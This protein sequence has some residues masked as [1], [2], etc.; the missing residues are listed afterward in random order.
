MK[1]LLA[2]LFPFIAAAQT[3]DDLIGTWKL[4]TAWSIRPGGERTPMYGERP[5]GFLTYTREGRMIAILGNGERKRL[6][7][8]RATSPEAERAEAFSTMLSYGG[9]FSIED[10]KVIH[11]VDI[12]TYPNFVGTDQVRYMKLDGDRLT[13]S[14]RGA[15]GQLTGEL[16]WQR[17]K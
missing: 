11:H 14:V 2:L 5:N 16:L 10:N 7:G 1:T 8:N 4:V 6:S 3:K 9:T 17:L 13:L 12:A 15:N